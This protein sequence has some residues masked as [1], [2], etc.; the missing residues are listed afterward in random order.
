MERIG[1]DLL[2]DSGFSQKQAGAVQCGHM[3]Y[4]LYSNASSGCTVRG[5]KIC[6][7]RDQLICIERIQ[8]NEGVNPYSRMG[9]VYPYFHAVSVG[10]VYLA[11]MD[12]LKREKIL[13]KIGLPK[14]YS[15][16]FRL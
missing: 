15:S 16:G 1:D 5:Q 2:S 11:H 12:P 8:G 6:P 9:S 13:E 3:I 7:G 10:K 4:G 14:N